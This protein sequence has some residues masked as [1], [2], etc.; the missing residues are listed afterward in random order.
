MTHLSAYILA[1]NRLCH[2][3][4]L[5]KV[6]FQFS[7]YRNCN[8]RHSLKLQ[9]LISYKL[10]GILNIRDVAWAFLFLSPLDIVTFVLNHVFRVLLDCLISQALNP[11]S[12]SI[13]GPL[14]M[15][16]LMSPSFRS[17][18]HVYLRCTSCICFCTNWQG[19]LINFLWTHV[20]K[21]NWFWIFNNF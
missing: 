2:A 4:R 11:S 13:M 21:I 19:S 5:I 1:R 15:S 10:S 12:K 18:A 7:W 20:T 8:T 9:T 14:A 16:Y 6:H 3:H 17:I